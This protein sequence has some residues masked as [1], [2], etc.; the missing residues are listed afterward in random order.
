M[1]VYWGEELR[2]SRKV[3][4]LDYTPEEK[5]IQMKPISPDDIIEYCLSTIGATSYGEI[6]N[7]HATIVDLNLENHPQRTCQKL[8]ME[9]A[10]M[11]SSA[12]LSIFVE[13]WSSIDS[14]VSVDSGKTGYIVDRQRIQSIRAQYV[15]KY[16]DF[17]RRPVWQ[18]Y[19]S[20]SI[21]GRLYQNAV[22]YRYG[23]ENEIEMIF[24]QLNLNDSTSVGSNR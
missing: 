14:L 17:L 18:T 1:E 8:A 24:S 3:R 12:G 13:R 16:P 22:K 15:E 11:F 6:Y 7:I 5:K 9:L 2:L 4:P 19:K 10:K 20:K 21:V 23:K